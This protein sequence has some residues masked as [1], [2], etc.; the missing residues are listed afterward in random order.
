[1]IS[2]Q[3]NLD[4]LS[5]M[6]QVALLQA[7]QALAGAEAATQND[8][9]LVNL[10]SIV[11]VRVRVLEVSSSDESS[12]VHLAIQVVGGATGS[13]GIFDILAGVERNPHE[14]ILGAVRKWIRFTFPPIRAALSQTETFDPTIGVTQLVARPDLQWKV[15]I[16]NPLI[17]G[18][19][20]DTARVQS[21]LV[22]EKS[23]FPGIVGD[24]VAA[25][26]NTAERR[27][28]WVKLLVASS[29]GSTVVECQF[30]NGEYPELDRLV[31]AEFKFPPLI[32]DF[33][34][35][36]QFVVIKPD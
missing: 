31:A 17:L 26:L 8:R 27:L 33:I 36:K 16:G 18:Q 7:L 29:S 9:I 21:A 25:R 30:D 34:S 32:G 22:S 1:V 24:T 35:V 28:H 5:N 2:A 19:Q 12:V 23:L 6:A 3:H 10:G 20:A 11:T 4:E 13:D 14:A 15:Y